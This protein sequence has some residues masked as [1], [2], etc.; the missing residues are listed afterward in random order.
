MAVYPFEQLGIDMDF[1]ARD[2]IN[3]NFEK[4]GNYLESLQ[5]QIN[6]L[7]LEAGSSEPEVL[8]AR[9]GYDG[10][11]YETLNDRLNA[12]VIPQSKQDEWDAK[13]DPVLVTSSVDGLMRKEDKFILDA[14]ATKPNWVIPTLQN[15][16]QSR[17]GLAYAKRADGVIM[18]KGGFIGGALGATVFNLPAGYRPGQTRYFVVPDAGANGTLFVMAIDTNGNVS[19]VRTIGTGTLV[20]V[21]GISFYDLAGV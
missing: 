19:V 5:S 2:R 16:W 6:T 17:A 10:V 21:D 7:V 9:V 3:G 13:S 8:Q 1:E 12:E 15:N 11:V 20:Y 18:F 4:A 14:L